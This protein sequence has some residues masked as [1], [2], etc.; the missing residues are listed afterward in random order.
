MKGS[1]VTTVYKIRRIKDG[2]FSKGGKTP[3][4][5]KKGKTWSSLGHL[6]NHMVG[7]SNQKYSG[8][9]VVKYELKTTATA[10]VGVTFANT[11]ENIFQSFFPEKARLAKELAAERARIDAE[12]DAA[13]K[14]H[15][16]TIIIEDTPT[17]SCTLPTITSE[18]LTEVEV[19]PEP[20]TQTI[21]TSTK[22]DGPP[23]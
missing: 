12:E 7:K 1:L 22:K 19:A 4:F 11:S 21:T 10:K 9:E 23:W 15:E 14:A 8:C 2:L 5:S 13:L 16:A 20:V 17:A 6:K 18:P 3:T